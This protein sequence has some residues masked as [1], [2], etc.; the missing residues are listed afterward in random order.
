MATDGYVQL[1]RPSVLPNRVPLH[2][3]VRPVRGGFRGCDPAVKAPV[4]QPHPVCLA[5]PRD[6]AGLLPMRVQNVHFLIHRHRVAPSYQRPARQRLIADLRLPVT[7]FF[8]LVALDYRNDLRSGYPPSPTRE[9]PRPTPSVTPDR[10][11]SKTFVYQ[12]FA[13]YSYHALCPWRGRLSVSGPRR[14]R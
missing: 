3:E 6:P 12:R 7:C 2:E 5:L 10:R 1:V 14:D 13:T 8:Q 11:R 4:P 9:R